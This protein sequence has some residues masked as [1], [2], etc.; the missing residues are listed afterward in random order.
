MSQMLV[1]SRLYLLGSLRR[2]AH[3]AAG[4]VALALLFLPSYVNAFS[5][6]LHGFER[7]AKDFGLTLMGLFSVAM[8][9]LLGSTTVQRDLTSRA[10]Y[11]V[12]ARPLSRGAYLGAHYLALLLLLA[13][14]LLTQAAALCAGLAWLTRSFD[15]SV[16]VAS[17]GIFL[18]AAVLGAVCLTF[19]I[20]CS[21]PLAG[22]IGVA[23]FLIGNLS[24]AF[25]RFF[26]VEDRD[27]VVSAALARGLKAIVPNLSLLDLK[28]PAVHHLT[29][30]AGYLPAISYYSLVWVVLLL[31]LAQLTFRRLD[32]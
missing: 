11:P 10:L 31:L 16:L 28:D 7:V 17:Y 21:P 6:G 8:A 15:A 29:L 13:G 3:L 25:I 1:L 4:L 18:Q 19:S 30:P 2:Q 32:L 24:G 9:V 20:R 22:T 27:S 14:S 5:L 26:L 12:L 23:S